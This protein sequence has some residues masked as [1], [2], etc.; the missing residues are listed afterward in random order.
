[1]ENY[2]D[3][4]SITLTES[5][6]D[7]WLTKV[8]AG[9]LHEF[10]AGLKP[11][12][13]SVKFDRP[14]KDQIDGTNRGPRTLVRWVDVFVNCLLPEDLSHRVTT[15]VY[16]EETQTKSGLCPDYWFCKA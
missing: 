5:T 8:T 4:A 15:H 1:M 16:D 12:I 13:L 7:H 9:T 14:R 11:D 2:W 6:E 3:C 10:N